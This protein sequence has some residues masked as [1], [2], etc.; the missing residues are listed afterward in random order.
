MTFQDELINCMDILAAMAIWTNVFEEEFPT[1]FSLV[2]WMQMT[3]SLQ[4]IFAMS[5]RALSKKK[6][7]D[8]I[9]HQINQ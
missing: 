8:I 5:E 1:W 3:L 2:I 6:E 9:V 7:L 4:L